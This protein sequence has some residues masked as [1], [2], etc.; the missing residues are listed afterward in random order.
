MRTDG[1]PI[2][3][4]GSYVSAG[5]AEMEAPVNIHDGTKLTSITIRGFDAHP[6]TNL[7][8]R[9][10]ERGNDPTRGFSTYATYTSSGN[11]GFFEATLPMNAGLNTETRELF[12]EVLVEGGAWDT[13]GLL[14]VNEITIDYWHYVFLGSSN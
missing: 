14:S 10:I 4:R 7:K 8:I 6:T 12:V 2:N 5:F 1:S 13:Q 3:G 11:G 9:L